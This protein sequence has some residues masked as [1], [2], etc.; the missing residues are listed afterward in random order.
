MARQGKRQKTMWGWMRFKR[1]VRGRWLLGILAVT[2]MLQLITAGITGHLFLAAVN[3]FI[4]VMLI[5]LVFR[6]RTVLAAIRKQAEEACRT[7]TDFL[8]NISHEIRTPLNSIIGFSELLRD[9]NLDD[10]QVEYLDSILINGQN[11]L[12]MVNDILDF[13][14]ITAGRSRL[15]NEPVVLP[16]LAE[17]LEKTFYPAARRKGVDFEI[18][19]GTGVP[20]TVVV[21]ASRLMQCLSNLV[22]NALKFTYE[23]Y[24]RVVV[25]AFEEC[26]RPALRFDIEDTGIGIPLDRQ[27]H[28][29]EA[30]TQ[31]DGSAARRYGGIGLGLTLSCRL[32]NLMGGRIAFTSEPGCGSTFSVVVPYRI[33]QGQQNGCLES[34]LQYAV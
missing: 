13:S 17:R 27:T 7:R 12:L 16:H 20:Q 5:I 30:F 2:A 34:T 11:L 15:N 22:H 1:R 32:A 24:I 26:G 21:D 3:V 23:G 10:E 4:I 33:Y 14:T 31:A 6:D 19:F 28:I 18:S 9:T 29:F 25:E 8:T